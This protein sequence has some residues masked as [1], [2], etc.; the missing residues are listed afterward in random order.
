M[1]ATATKTTVVVTK[2]ELTEIADW[3][4]KH[5]AAKKKVSE[6]EKELAFRRQSLAEK[7]LGVNSSEEMKELAPE[8][9][10]KLY[11]KRLAEGD[12]KLE[13]GAPSFAFVKTNQGQYPAW[14]KLY[15]EELGETAAAEIRK[16]TPLV[17]SYCVEVAIPA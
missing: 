6:A 16:N 7:V 2:D 4:R 11:A 3:E 13:R 9:L 14:S 5:S 12:W 1:P 15:I 8:K 10:L 17:Y